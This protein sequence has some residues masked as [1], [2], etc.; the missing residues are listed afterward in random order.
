MKTSRLEPMRNLY[1]GRLA[2]IALIVAV[3][4]ACSGASTA[5]PPGASA[6]TASASPTATPAETVASLLA[7]FGPGQITTKHM[8]TASPSWVARIDA[9]ADGAANIDDAVPGMRNLV[10]LVDEAAREGDLMSLI[11][12]CF[13][14]QTDAAF[15][16]QG[17][18][19]LGTSGALAA[20]SFLLESTH[21]IS[22][23]GLIYPSFSLTPG[24]PDATMTADAKAL[25]A[26]SMSAYLKTGM[27]T[28]FLRPAGANVDQSAHWGGVY[29]GFGA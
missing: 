24:Q 17:A 15:G 8:P 7:A 3:A 12:L 5:G 28:V 4:T 19:S 27:V 20:L 13:E 2:A 18:Q 1:P 6:T 26:T 10:A 16:S 29:I 22:Q 21:A 11:R 14:C 23:D 9:S 25:G